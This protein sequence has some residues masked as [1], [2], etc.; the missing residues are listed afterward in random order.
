VIALVSASL[1]ALNV[2]DQVVRLCAKHVREDF[3]EFRLKAKWAHPLSLRVLEQGACLVQL[4]R[5]SLSINRSQQI[6]S[7]DLSCVCVCV[8]VCV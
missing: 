7:A 4:E 8:C 2:H 5:V 6:R 1:S 3:Q